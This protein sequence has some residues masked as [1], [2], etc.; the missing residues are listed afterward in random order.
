MKKLI[1]SHKDL[2]LKMEQLEKG[3]SKQDE[4]IAL[5]FQYLKR[6]INVHE[7]PREQVG[8]KREDER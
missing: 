2:L 3:V 6:F 7:K 5:V 4:K 8:F 1:L